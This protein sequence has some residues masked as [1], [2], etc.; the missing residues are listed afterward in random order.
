[1][2][3]E[4]KSL[5]VIET[6]RNT[7]LT[8]AQNLTV[9]SNETKLQAETILSVIRKQLKFIES[10]RKSWTQ[11]LEDQKKRLI[12]IFK[13]AAAPL[14]STDYKL[15][16]ELD[17]YRIKLEQA[18]RKEEARLMA[19]QEKRN[20]RAMANGKPNPLPETIIPCVPQPEKTSGGVTYIKKYKA[21]ISNEAQ[22]PVFFGT[23]Q[24]R[25][26]DMVAVNKLVSAGVRDIPG[27]EVKEENVLRVN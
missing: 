5:Q 23:V 20:E 22:V 11:P 15:T 8:E 21:Y 14:V 6:N 1:M 17:Q 12:E 24:L 13:N 16:C 19:L 25:P 4:I 26:V 10:E 3:T 9:I 7:I 2:E 27:I 18:A